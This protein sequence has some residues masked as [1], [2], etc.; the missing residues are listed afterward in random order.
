MP[1]VVQGTRTT[2]TQS[3]ETRRVRD[4]FPTMLTLEPE[5]APLTVLMGKVQ[6]SEAV[7]PKIEWFEL[8]RL[9]KQDVLNA[10][11]ASGDTT[12][13]VTN[14]KY[15]RAGD[16]IQFVE[17]GEQALVSATPTTTT[18]TIT[19][20]W[21]EVSAAAVTNATKIRIVG[22]ANEED[23][24]GRDVISVTRAAKFNYLGI[25]REPFSI[26]N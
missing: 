26:S 12:I 21:G 20:A 7:D 10:S 14:Y 8:E 4:V 11:V 22:N 19:R 16:V 3:T 17:T 25:L 6:K 2:D 1:T 23:A 15:F 18:V 5:A 24:T 9:P 13:T